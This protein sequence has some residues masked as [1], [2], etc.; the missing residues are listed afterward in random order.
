AAPSTVVSLPTAG[1]GA[2]S[3]E[4][5]RH[6]NEVVVDLD[7]NAGGK[8]FDSRRGLRASELDLSALAKHL[9]SVEQRAPARGG[10]HL[11]ALTRSYE[12]AKEG[13]SAA[14]ERAASLA[15]D[16]QA[17]QASLKEAHDSLQA[18]Q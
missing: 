6:E 7:F 11:E 13:E 3:T 16:L 4:P 18:E 17:A 12:R 10:A 1:L 14:A 8:E 15:A 9:R 5:D 2:S